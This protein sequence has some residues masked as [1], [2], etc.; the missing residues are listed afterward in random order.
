MFGIFFGEARRDDFFNVDV[1][2]ESEEEQG[3]DHIPIFFFEILRLV[4]VEFI[5]ALEFEVR[6]DFVYKLPI[7]FRYFGRTSQDVCRVTVAEG[8]AV[9][10]QLVIESV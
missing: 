2:R 4:F 3:N 5:L 7:L 6:E 9:S 1:E 10:S 8:I